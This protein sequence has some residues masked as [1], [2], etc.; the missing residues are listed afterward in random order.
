MRARSWRTLTAFTVLLAV[1]AA[2]RTA[3]GTEFDTAMEPLVA[4][5][6]QIQTSLAADSTEGVAE[7]VRKIE[8]LARKLDPAEAAVEHREHYEN[9]PERIISACGMFTDP[10]DISS[11]REAFQELSKPVSMW[12]S[13]AKPEGER[14]M[15]CPMK[16]AGWVQQ[17]SEVANPYYGAAMLRCGTEVG[18]SR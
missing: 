13:M 6:L 7:S 11:T 9:I 1:G 14:V 15:Y 3:H 10:T 4:E 16:K 12:V 2:S 8:D 5:Y 17:G 18:G